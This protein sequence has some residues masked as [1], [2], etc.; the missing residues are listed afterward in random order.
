MVVGMPRRKR[1]PDHGAVAALAAAH[2]HADTRLIAETLRLRVAQDETLTDHE[3]ADL[4]ALAE[5][6]ERA[7]QE[8]HTLYRASRRAADEQRSVQP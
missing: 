5:E 7:N 6:H 1:Y 2:G 3:R 8:R 4:I